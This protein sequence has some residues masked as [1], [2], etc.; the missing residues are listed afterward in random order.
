M[1]RKSIKLEECAIKLDSKSG[2]FSGYASVFGGVDAVG[3]TIVRGAYENTL[4]TNG[5]PKMFFNHDSYA[6]PI[7]KWMAAKED[8]HG[9]FVEGELTAGN[10][11]SDAV[12]AALKHGTVDG[13]SIGYFLKKGDFDETESGRVIRKISRLVEVSVVT[14]PSDGG[15]RVDLASVKAEDVEALETIR[16]FERFL[17]DAGGLSKGLAAALVNRAKIIFKPEEPEVDEIE[18]KAMAAIRERFQTM[19]VAL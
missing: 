14:F 7:G 18:A 1:L 17:R 5:K 15:A 16:D 8:E 10:P 2:H 11:Q 12:R 13:L 4:R 9:L 6:L 3:D 19:H